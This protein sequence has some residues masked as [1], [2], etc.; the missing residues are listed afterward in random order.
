MAAWW[1][2]ISIAIP[3]D[4]ILGKDA[5]ECGPRF[6]TL[7]KDESVCVVIHAEQMDSAYVQRHL[8]VCLEKHPNMAIY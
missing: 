6:D 5:G 4:G 1:T 2:Y 8:L 7:L 3:T